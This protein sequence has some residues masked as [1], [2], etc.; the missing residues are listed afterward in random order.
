VASSSLTSLPAK[1]GA[2]RILDDAD[3]LRR[4]NAGESV[5]SI[6]GD[7]AVSAEGVYNC[8][9]RQ[10][11]S[12]TNPNGYKMYS[13]GKPLTS[14]QTEHRIYRLHKR[15]WGPTKIGTHLGLSKWAV[16]RAI[17]RRERIVLALAEAKIHRQ[18]LKE[19][20]H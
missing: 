14:K 9:H 13:Q 7:Y 5:V 6:A 18:Q 17:K 16:M 10:A 3:V 20:K 2:P 15:G 4:Y 1:V 11:E 12:P 8:L 19:G